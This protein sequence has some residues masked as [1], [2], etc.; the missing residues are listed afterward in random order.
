[1][2][3]LTLVFINTEIYTYVEIIQEGEVAPARRN[4]LHIT[5]GDIQA[6]E[7]PTAVRIFFLDFGRVTSVG[8]ARSAVRSVKESRK[9]RK[10][11]NTGSSNG[12]RRSFHVTLS[13]PLSSARFLPYLWLRGQILLRSDP[14]LF[15]S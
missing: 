11:E 2:V 15:G 8:V 6:G 13:R 14:H 3:M 4:A 10:E 5:F 9:E 12:Q 7:K 1:M